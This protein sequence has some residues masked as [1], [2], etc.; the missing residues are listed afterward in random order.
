MNKSKIL[1]TP[2]LGAR[3][4]DFR[5]QYKIKAKDVAMMLDKSAAYVSKLEKGEIQQIERLEF[6]R[7]LNFI[8]GDDGYKKFIEYV[9]DL[10]DEEELRESTLL[11]NF[12]WLERILPIPEELVE[13]INSKIEKN[14]VDI[15]SLTEYINKNDDL[16]T[17][18]FE[19][20]NIDKEKVESNV[21]IN[22][23]DVDSNSVRRCFILVNVNQKEIEDI[24]GGIQK[25]SN[26]LKVFVILYH[27][28]KL[29]DLSKCL[30]LQ[31]KDRTLAQ[32]KTEEKLQKYKFYTYASKRKQ[33]LKLQ[34]Q[35]ELDDVLSKFD[36]TNGMLTNKLI[37][38]ISF[39]S[40]MD[41]SYTNIKLEGI[42]N[43]F[44][45]IDPS[46][47]IAYMAIPLEKLK[48]LPISVKK[49]FLKGVNELIQKCCDIE[50]KSQG[51]EKY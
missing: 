31:E 50:D 17:A 39:L 34:G 15:G 40:E 26:Y 35:F 49:D 13:Y 7:I 3:L 5:N 21:W 2:E 12:D 37:S 48:E 18:F 47:A 25:K 27:I 41:V 24:L 32:Q 22:Y 38:Y 8:A 36:A 16:D 28:F 11:L 19:K 44:E 1:I 51:F 29:E 4:K 14:K 45:K 42:I 33:L 23:R 20:H 9:S 10:A 43:N 30:I 46:F 6:E